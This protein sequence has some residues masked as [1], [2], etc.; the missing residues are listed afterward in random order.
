MVVEPCY[1]SAES[2][3]PRAKI[4]RDNN[5]LRGG[6]EDCAGAS[7]KLK[8]LE[9]ITSSQRYYGEESESLRRF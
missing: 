3:H 7:G 9:N 6:Y 8:M 1:G 2:Q 4:N 5:G